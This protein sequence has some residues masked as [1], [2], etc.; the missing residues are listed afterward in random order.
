MPSDEVREAYI[1]NKLTPEELL[2]INLKEWI[3]KTKG[4]SLAHMRELVIS[5]CAMGNTFEDTMDRLNGL[6]IKPRIKSKNKE[7]GFNKK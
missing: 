2:S 5:V 7:V 4:L 6:K 1:K 3:E